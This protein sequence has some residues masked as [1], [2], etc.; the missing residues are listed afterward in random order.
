MDSSQHDPLG[1][2]DRTRTDD[3]LLAY[4]VLGQSRGDL[5]HELKGVPDPWRPYRV[6]A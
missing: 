3:P 4:Q 1:G 2:D 5:E 6:V